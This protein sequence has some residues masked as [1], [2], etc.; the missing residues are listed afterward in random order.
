MSAFA[1]EFL[2]SQFPFLLCVGA[3]SR[4]DAANAINHLLNM[5]TPT[6]G[7]RPGLPLVKTGKQN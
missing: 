2:L 7:I 1:F 3:L 6:T 5:K 4:I